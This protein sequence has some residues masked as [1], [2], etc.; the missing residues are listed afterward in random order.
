M[1]PSARSQSVGKLER[2]N[3]QL[4]FVTA[5]MNVPNVYSVRG[6]DTAERRVRQVE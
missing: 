2:A 6:S 4:T 3:I 5:M 1:Q